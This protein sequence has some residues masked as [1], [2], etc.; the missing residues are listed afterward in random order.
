MF[1]TFDKNI[2][3]RKQ[4]QVSSVSHCIDIK[5]NFLLFHHC[6]T[7]REHSLQLNRVVKGKICESSFIFPKK[8]FRLTITDLKNMLKVCFIHN[9]ESNSI[10]F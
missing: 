8:N 1:I 5:A 4:A 9:E 3:F 6:I 2:F 10:Y 7:M